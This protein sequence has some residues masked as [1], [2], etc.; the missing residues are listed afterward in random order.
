MFGPRGGRWSSWDEDGNG[1]PIYLIL[2]EGNFEG[3]SIPNLIDY[4]V[5]NDRINHCRENCFQ[6][7]KD[8]FILI[9][10]IRF[11]HLGTA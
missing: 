10:M 6:R 4:I 7:E 11:L 3:K 8:V 5:E 2:S 1:F 9:K